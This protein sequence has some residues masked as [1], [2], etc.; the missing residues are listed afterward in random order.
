MDL[1]FTFQ[2]TLS[3]RG[4]NPGMGVSGALRR[5]REFIRADIA[6]PFRALYEAA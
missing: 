6:R 4:P 5:I 1:G 3:E 2:I